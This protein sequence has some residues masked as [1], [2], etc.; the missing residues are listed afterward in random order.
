MDYQVTNQLSEHDIPEIL[1]Q[2]GLVSTHD[3]SEASQL[4]KRLQIPV[5]RALIN[6]NC[7]DQPLLDMALDLQNMVK[8]KL[9]S[10]EDAFSCLRRLA[11]G[12]VTADEL[13]DEIYSSPRF[14]QNTKLLAELLGRSG[15]VAKDQLDLVLAGSAKAAE[16]TLKGIL[17]KEGLLS[18]GLLPALLRLQE[19]LRQGRVSM[20]QASEQLKTEYDFWLK[21]EESQRLAALASEAQ[22]EA[23]AAVK[24][25]KHH[26]AHAKSIGKTMVPAYTEGRPLTPTLSHF[27]EAAGFVGRKDLQVAYDKLLANPKL[28][29]QVFESLGLVKPEDLATVL[30]CH[31]LV[32]KGELG[33]DEAIQAL[34]ISKTKKVRLKRALEEMSGWSAAQARK[35]RRNGLIAG[36]AM[37]SLAVLGG[38][39]LFAWAKDLMSATKERFGLAGDTE[40][41]P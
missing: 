28:S 30:E 36:V 38:F 10:R 4:S 31:N 19:K 2:S 26:A 13:L 17:I 8:E 14:A 11:R 39:G 1:V 22:S 37:G 16:S 25:L 34:K 15:I 12:Q 5:S 35:E 6:T 18:A 33:N 32:L 9:L 3:L 7:I 20:E 29:A 40:E 27:L 41:I 23:A 21:A 24:D